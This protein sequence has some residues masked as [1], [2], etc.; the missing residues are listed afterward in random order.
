MDLQKRFRI[1]KNADELMAKGNI[2]GRRVALE[3][4]EHALKSVDAY[5]AVKRTVGLEDDNLR[6]GELTLN[7]SRLRNIYVLGAGKASFEIAKALEETLQE[8]IRDGVIIEKRGRGQ[9]LS[10][11]RVFEAGHPVPDEA[12]VQGAME[13]AKLAEEAGEGDLVFVAVTGGCSA[14]MPLPAGGLT[15]EDKR[16]VTGL[17]LECGATIDEINAVR[18]HLSEIKGGRLALMIHPAEMVNLI[19]VDE[20][21]GRPW[22]PTIPD[23]TTFSDAVAVMKKHDLWSTVPEAV[24]LHLEKAE[25]KTETPKPREFEAIGVRSR[26]FILARNED[27]CEAA[28]EEAERLGYKA[29]ILTTV[30]EGESKDVGVVLSSVAREV[31]LRWRPIKPPCVVISGGET[32]VTIRGEAGEGGRNQ[33]LALSASLKIAGSERIVVA[34]LGTDGTDGPTDIAGAIVDGYTAGRARA[35]GIDVEQEIKRHNSSPVFRA[36]RDAIYTGPTGTN[37]MDL[38]VIVVTS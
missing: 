17:L 13:A 8:R 30:L 23:E 15:I 25:P 35:M 1:I 36:L 20:V 33:E 31:E 34:S 29:S 26:T 21:A 12:G 28:A 6:V 37:V 11:I 10:R 22:G 18:K 5:E 4:L 19:V 16:K 7:L 24:R 2:E 9:K 27:A 38:Q 3:V 32:T 14:L